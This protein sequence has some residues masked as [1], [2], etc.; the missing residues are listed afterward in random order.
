MSLVF[1]TAAE[2][3]LQTPIYTFSP[4][5]TPLTNI[6]NSTVYTYD[7]ALGVWTATTAGGG[8]GGSSFPS[9]TKIVFAQVSAPQGWVQVPDATYN[10]AAIR[11]VTS[12]GGGT[13]G[14]G[15]FST[16][17]TSTRSVPLLQHTHVIS[18]TTHSHAFW[19]QQYNEGVNSGGATVMDGIAFSGS[20]TLPNEV[21]I[22]SSTPG[23]TADVSGT[24]GAAM[25]FAVK[26]V[27]MIVATKS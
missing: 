5:S 11:L 2:A 3:A 27:D 22:S 6:T 13:G 24:A 17:F 18:N 26:Y 7:P 14:S 1:P 16:T 25:D 10:D 19:F 12:A 9:G 23:I 15:A 21:V 4:I 8:G 20:A